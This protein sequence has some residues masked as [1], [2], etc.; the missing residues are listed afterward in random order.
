MLFYSY[1][2]VKREAALMSL[3]DDVLLWYEWEH[4][5]RPIRDWEDLKGLIHCQYKCSMVETHQ[6]NL[7]EAVAVTNDRSR[8]KC[9]STIS[10]EFSQIHT[11]RPPPVIIITTIRI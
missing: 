3:K 6:W 9:C 8:E 11:G 4:R 5:R 1:E 10:E 7:I 2:E